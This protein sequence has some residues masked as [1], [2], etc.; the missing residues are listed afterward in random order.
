MGRA[1]AYLIGIAIVG[2]LSIA[3]VGALSIASAQP[4]DSLA[5]L[6]RV[7]QE[8]SPAARPMMRWW[9]F[10]PAVTP[11]GLDR[12]LQAMHDAGL[13]GVEVQ[14]VYPLVPDDR[15]RGLVNHPFLSAPF[16]DAVRHSAETARRLGLRFDLTLGSGWPYGGPH[17]SIDHAAGRLRWEKVPVPAASR[18]VPLPPMTTGERL[19]AVTRPEGGAELTDIRGDAVWL[20][21]GARPSE[22]WVFIAGPTGMMVKRAAV[23]AEG[24]VLDHYDRAAL[25]AHLDAVGTPLLDALRGLAPATVFCDSLEVFGSDWTPDLLAEFARRRGYDLRPHLPALVTGTDARAVGLRQD[26]GRTL[27]ELYEERFLAPLAAWT[28]ARGSKLRIQ[29]YGIPPATLSSN[30]L[31]DLTDGEGAQWKTITPARWASSANHLFDRPVTASETWTWLHSPSFAAT[32]L[33][34]KAEADRHF[35]QGVNQMIGHG[36]PST[37]DAVDDGAWRFNWRFYAAAALNDRNPWWIAMPDVSRYLQRV[38]ALLR[39][40]R[41]VNDVALYLP[42]DDALGDIKP[43]TAHLLELLRERIGPVVPAAILDAGFGFDVIDDAALGTG[44]PASMAGGALTVGG[45]SY[46]VIVLPAVVTMP[47]E[48]QATL[49][50]FIAGGGRVVAVDRLPER[51]PGLRGEPL[52][53]GLTLTP[54]PA[55]SLGAALQAALTPDIRLE[56]AS[57]DV[58]QHHRRVGDA[59][60]YFV[61]NTANTPRAARLTVRTMGRAEWWDPLTGESRRADPVAVGRD[62]M[63]VALDLPAY[64]S[65]VLVVARGPAPRSSRLTALPAPAPRILPIAGPWTIAFADR[66]IAPRT[67]DSLASWDADED[68]RYFSG[69]ATYEA[70]LELP[71]IPAGAAV[72]LDFG[73]GTAVTPNDRGPGMR[74]WL[75]APIRDAAVIAIN[76][77]P[78]GAVW[79]PPFRLDVTRL[80]KPGRNAVSIRVGNTAL[81]HMAGRPLPD[82]RLLNLRYGDRF[83]P[84]TMEQVRPL[85]SGLVGP[86]RL[87]ITPPRPR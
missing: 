24:Y 47:A 77:Q 86:V 12:E 23:G 35:L 3:I 6:R 74:T 42:T 54:T 4:A 9:W 28:H 38:S 49:R 80:V 41:A 36:W 71:A 46:R 52:P 20:P 57:P 75:D 34:L 67:R 65:T 83:Q 33:D 25:Q 30:R 64:G 15:G 51:T 69:V 14:P 13:G 48:T 7:W 5:P 21:E 17:I 32:P 87:E 11:Q 44:T 68:T 63:T 66:S 53:A 50:A 85:P 8:P 70:A 82:Y 1:H 45:Q 84:Q 78:A 62:T 37:P 58:G 39:E 43:G 73:P 76:G 18:R 56:P 22:L 40:G 81:N 60:V 31:A 26:W 2:A 59:D 10:G 27:G 61:A 16:L 55:T 79:C 29:G 72:V 19:I